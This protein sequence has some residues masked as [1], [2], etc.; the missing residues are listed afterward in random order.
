M[1]KNGADGARNAGLS[2]KKEHEQAS[3]TVEGMKRKRASYRMN[4]HQGS[5][6]SERDGMGKNCGSSNIP[7]DENSMSG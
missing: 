4:A 7:T 2:K 6:K 1:G 3:C 5:E